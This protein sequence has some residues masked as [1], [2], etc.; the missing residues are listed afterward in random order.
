MALS[1]DYID[2]LFLFAVYNGTVGI[3]RLLLMISII[4]IPSFHIEPYSSTIAI[5]NIHQYSTSP[6]KIFVPTDSPI[7]TVVSDI[8][9]LLSSYFKQKLCF[10]LIRLHLTLEFVFL[11]ACSV[12]GTKFVYNMFITRSAETWYDIAGHFLGGFCIFV[13]I[14][15][16]TTVYRM[17]FLIEQISE[18]VLSTE[19]GSERLE[20]VVV[21]G[22]EEHDKFLGAQPLQKLEDV[23]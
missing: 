16:A 17:F 18:E 15:G 4:M 14:F 9:N 21:N 23:S 2:K 10:F 8:S 20:N 13:F 7:F 1:Q 6:I 3:K 11:T 5:T 22:G 19:N 12:A